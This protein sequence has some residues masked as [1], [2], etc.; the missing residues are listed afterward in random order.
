MV[1]IGGV[2]NALRGADADS[3]NVAERVPYRK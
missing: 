2:G 1:I 3:R